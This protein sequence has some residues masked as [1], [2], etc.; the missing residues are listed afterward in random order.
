MCTPQYITSKTFT[1]QQLNIASVWAA[2]A[3]CISINVR[4]LISNRHAPAPAV[5]TRLDRATCPPDINRS[6]CVAAQIPQRHQPYSFARD[7]VIRIT[8]AAPSV[9][10]YCLPPL[11][12]R[13]CDQTPGA[14]LRI[15]KRGITANI[16]VFDKRLF[17][18]GIKAVI[19]SSLS[20]P[21]DHAWALA[22]ANGALMH[23]AVLGWCRRF[24]HLLCGVAHPQAGRIFCYR[25]GTGIKSRKRRREKSFR[26]WLLCG[27][28][29]HQPARAPVFYWRQLQYGRGICPTGNPRANSSRH[30]LSATFATAWK[31]VAQARLTLKHRYAH[32]FQYR[33]QFH[34]QCWGFR[35]LYDL[36]KNQL[37]NHFG[38]NSLR[39]S[40]SPTT[41]FPKSTAG[42]PEKPSPGGQKAY[43]NR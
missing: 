31:L 19:T 42:M 21:S 3:S 22:D 33:E 30:R 17:I 23:L 5:L 11:P 15:G 39:A 1:T 12:F 26:R 8:A 34:A 32:S 7:S 9:S 6:K 29:W 16:V 25:S 35:H 43:V 27:L 18:R 4:S 24:R 2:K 20:L 14:A 37:F 28:C 38:G 41:I 10:G 13:V 36:T 40:S